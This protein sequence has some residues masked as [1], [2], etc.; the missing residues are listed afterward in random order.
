MLTGRSPGRLSPEDFNELIEEGIVTLDVDQARKE[1]EPFV[2]HPES[3][4]IWSHFF[5]RDVARRIKIR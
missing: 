1:V 2:K 3:L 5:F 4:Q